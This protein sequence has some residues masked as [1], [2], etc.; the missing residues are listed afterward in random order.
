MAIIR[1]RVPFPPSEKCHTNTFRISSFIASSQIVY[2]SWLHYYSPYPA[3]STVSLRIIF[4]FAWSSSIN[5]IFSADFSQMFFFFLNLCWPLT[6]SASCNIYFACYQLF[7]IFT[8]VF[9]GVGVVRWWWWMN[10]VVNGSE[11]S[12]TSLSHNSEHILLSSK[13]SHPQY[14]PNCLIYE[15]KKVFV[16]TIAMVGKSCFS[17]C[18]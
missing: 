16:F 14:L 17:P 9:W 3:V 11:I 5:L 12:S 6:I 13:L 1:P 8:W 15:E 7:C 4:I 18:I 10:G 2:Y